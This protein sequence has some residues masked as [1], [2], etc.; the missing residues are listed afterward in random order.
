VTQMRSCQ[1]HSYTALEVTITRNIFLI[2][3]WNYLPYQTRT[4][5]Y[6]ERF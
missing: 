3:F 4:E 6:F 2:S 1:I 5:L